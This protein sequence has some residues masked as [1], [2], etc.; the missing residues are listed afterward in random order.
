MNHF[1]ASSMSLLCC[2]RGQRLVLLT[3]ALSLAMLSRGA[4]ALAKP[5]ASVASTNAPVAEVPAPQSVF[6]MPAAPAD[7]K[8]PFFPRSMHP[9]SS[10][11]AVQTNV[12]V[13]ITADLRLNGMSGTPD[14]RL[15]II[16]SKTFDAGQ[17]Q[18][19]ATNAGKVRV[20]CIEIQ[21]DAAIIQIGAERRK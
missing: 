8:D 13:Q 9:Y 10:T 16:N 7:G 19:V 20:R 3:V 18:E 15:V 17:E 5:T 14:H 11:R 12:V 6:V 21:P 1:N 4:C 2:S